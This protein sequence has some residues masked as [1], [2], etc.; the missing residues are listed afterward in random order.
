MLSARKKYTEIDE[1]FAQIEPEF[2]DDPQYLVDRLAHYE[3]Q[4][5]FSVELRMLEENEKLRE[6]LP[7]ETLKKRI[8]LY[9]QRENRQ[10]AIKL[11]YELFQNYGDLEAGYMAMV[12][13]IMNEDYIKAG[14][15]GQIIMSHTMET[16]VEPTAIFYHTMY[17]EA[18]ILDKLFQ[19]NPPEEVRGEILTMVDSYHTWMKEQHITTEEMDK[20]IAT[21]RKL[22]EGTEA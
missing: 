11:V 19:G 14:K 16:T 22:L 20:K 12:Y 3:K 21:V 4:G 10:M 9:L 17:L 8:K 5:K 2:S 13:E 1:M 6:L 18:I 15:I 7:E